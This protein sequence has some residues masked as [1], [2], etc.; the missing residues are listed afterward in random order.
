MARGQF[1]AGRH[2]LPPLRS[3][4]L[5][6]SAFVPITYH[7]PVRDVTVFTKN[8][9]RLLAGEV[10]QAFFK[11]VLSQAR[12]HGLLSAEH[13]TVDGISPDDTVCGRLLVGQG[14]LEPPVSR[15]TFLPRRMEVFC[16]RQEHKNSGLRHF[17]GHGTEGC[18]SGVR[19]LVGFTLHRDRRSSPLRESHSR[20]QIQP[21]S[22][23][24]SQFTV[25]DRLGSRRVS[26]WACRSDSSPWPAQRPS[27]PPRY[28]IGF[29]VAAGGP[30]EENPWGG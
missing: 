10:A 8:R 29:G 16:A 27:A 7:A 13:F 15:E 17:D 9:E 21:L 2:P 30:R 4:P 23:K 14:G 1:R 18:E 6:R 19:Y 12:T 24:L 25:N 11:A 28:L 20:F 26:V 5:T 22:R 3:V